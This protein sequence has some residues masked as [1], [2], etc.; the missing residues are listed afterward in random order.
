MVISQIFKI[1]AEINSTGTT[2]LLVEQ[3]AAAAIKLADRAYVIDQGGI[4]FDGTAEELRED[5]E[6]RE[7]Y[8]GV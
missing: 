1:I 7:R 3:N 2:V 5:D 8:L 4:V 6:T